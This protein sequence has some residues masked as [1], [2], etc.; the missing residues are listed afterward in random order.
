VKGDCLYPFSNRR[1]E[2]DLK[3]LKNIGLA[4]KALPFCHRLA[5]LREARQISFLRLLRR[6]AWVKVL[7]SEKG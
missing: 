5:S 6:W 1:L 2:N 7:E 4:K 3:K